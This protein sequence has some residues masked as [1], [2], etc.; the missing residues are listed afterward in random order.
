MITR[1][2]ELDEESD[3]ILAALAEDYEGNLGQAI[4]DLLH[5]REGV[6][7]MLDECETASFQSLKSQQERAE[8]GFREGRFTTWEQVSKDNGL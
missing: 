8:H 5:S 4:T 6:E 1:Q 2:I 7:A 3:R